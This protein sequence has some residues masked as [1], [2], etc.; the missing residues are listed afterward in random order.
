MTEPTPI[1]VLVVDDHPM[2]H[3]G[4]RHFLKAFPDLEL[5]G[6]AMNAQEALQL[7]PQAQP[8]VVLMDMVMP[9][10]D[11]VDA[12][13][14]LKERFPT[15]RVIIVTSYRE[16]DLVERALRAGASGYLLKNVSAFDLAQAIRTAYA[17]RS[18]LAA[19]ATAALLEMI[20]QQ[21]HE[22]EIALTDREREV[23]FLLVQG[24]S[25]AQIAD[26]LNISRATVKFHIGG[27]FTKLG[28]ANRAEAIALAYKQRLV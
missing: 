16:G 2:A 3:M 18:V 20:Q 6:E 4:M 10:M 23:L 22:T 14:L 19:E 12:T 17:G 27:I 28:V 15:I 7:C 13:R 11:G 8:H 25:N 9:G 26:Q 5:V 1:R 21:Q 24:L